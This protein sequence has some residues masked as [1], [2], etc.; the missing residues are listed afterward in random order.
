MAFDKS[1][2]EDITK[3]ATAHGFEPAALLA[4]AEV[5]SAGQAFALVDGRYEPLIR[6]EGHYF[7]KRLTPAQ[8]KMARAAGLSSPTAGKVANPATQSGRWALLN[9]AT[10]IN[11]QAAFESVS[12]GLGQV[13]GAHWQF[14][15]FASVTEMVNVCRRGAG[16]QAELMAR[17]IEKSGLAKA[18]R[19][20]DWA[21][22][23]KGYNGSNYGKNAYDTKM[24]TAYA[25]FARG[26]APGPAGDD[27]TRRLQ[28]LLTAAGFPTPADG[29]SGPKT[30]AAVKSFQRAHGLA[31]DGIAGPATMAALEAG[32]L[33]N[34]PATPAQ[35]PVVP[36]TA[37]KPT[38][39][40]KLSVADILNA[41]AAFFTG[42][43]R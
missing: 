17:F 32:K 28:E 24:A 5:E 7:D 1:V 23:A 6:F 20:H 4:V 26:T 42:K 37:P 41:M 33:P 25:K 2:I 3:V 8:Q 36:P 30:I 35:K 18:L 34:Q 27:K 12:W 38:P 11:A 21:T 9:R 31:V 29:I 15:D 22:F 39:A 40:Q 19:T 13:M 14:L 43:W 10:A 16:G